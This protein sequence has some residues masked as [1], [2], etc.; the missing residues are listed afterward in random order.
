MI[1]IESGL[2]TC[3]EKW[4]NSDINIVLAGVGATGSAVAS[5][6]F[7]LHHIR[8]EMTDNEFGLRLALFDPKSVSQ[9]GITELVFCA[10]RLDRIKPLI[11]R[12]N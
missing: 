6:L 1:N 10:L 8:K 2:Y 5:M 3:K 11:W 4:L 9:T 12:I 7:K